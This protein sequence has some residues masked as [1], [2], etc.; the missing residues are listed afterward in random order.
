M[1]DEKAQEKF[2]EPFLTAFSVK[3]PLVPSE[4]PWVRLVVFREKGKINISD[5]EKM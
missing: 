2:V 3:C 1:M 4:C 5:I